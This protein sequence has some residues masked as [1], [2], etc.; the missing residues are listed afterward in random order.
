MSDRAYPVT[1]TM[2][3]YTSAAIM[4]ELADII[5]PDDAE[6]SSRINELATCRR[7]WGEALQNKGFNSEFDI[8]GV[9]EFTMQKF[10]TTH[11]TISYA[12]DILSIIDNLISPN[13]GTAAQNGIKYTSDTITKLLKTFDENKKLRQLSCKRRCIRCGCIMER[14]ENECPECEAPENYHSPLGA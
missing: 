2:L 1:K 14:P 3:I 13:M 4:D 5:Y 10:Y 6:I 8:V 7:Q 12:T 11:D 9:G